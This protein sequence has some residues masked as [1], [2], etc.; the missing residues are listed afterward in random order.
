MVGLEAGGAEHGDA[1]AH[2]VERAEAAHELEEDADGA[3]QLEGAGL[4][5][6]EEADLL[7]DHRLL[8]PPGSVGGRRR[9]RPRRERRRMRGRWSYSGPRADCTAVSYTHLTLPTSDLV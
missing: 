3:G 1:R 9:G 6:L 4:R 7:G 5:P 2:V 8:A